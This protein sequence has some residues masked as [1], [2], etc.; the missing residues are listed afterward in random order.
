MPDAFR[1]VLAYPDVYDVGMA[2]QAI[3]ILYAALNDMEGVSCERTFVPWKDMADALRRRGAPLLA[4]E[5]LDPVAA[6]DIIG[7]TLPHELTYTNVCEL[8]D[9]AGVP[10]RACDRGPADPFV[11]AGGPCAY[12]P[13]PIAAFFDAILIGDGEEAAREI[14][15]VVREARQDGAS[16]TE[17]LERLRRIGG[18]Y[19]P[20]LDVP[21]TRTIRKR[22]VRD[23]TPFASPVCPVVPY[24]DVV[25]DRVA[26]E[27]LRGCVRGC[28]FCQAGMVY[29]PVRERG[30]DAVVRDAV[31]ALRCTGYEEVSLT[32]LSTADHS[33]FA[34]IVRRLVRRLEGTG[35]AISVPSLRLDAFTFELARLLGQ[36]KRA[37]LTFAP[38]AATQ[39]LRDVINKNITEHDVLSTVERAFAAGWRRVKLY[40]M[41]GLPTETD[42]D[43]AEIGALV[44]RVVETARGATPAGERG[45]V[46]VAVSVSTFVPKAHTPFQWEPQIPLGEVHRRHDIVRRVMPRK[47]VELSFH[48]AEASFLEAVL[49]RGGRELSDVIERAWQLGARFDAWSESFS[50]QRWMRAFEECGVDPSAIAHRAWPEDEPLPWAHVSAGLSERY[51]RIERRRALE[52]IRTPD[53]A[54]AGCTGCG[55]CGTLGGSNVIVGDRRG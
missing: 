23:L 42:E 2:N 22:L 45:S 20:L 40:F 35:I 47:G 54:V 12:N 37:S 50:L 1:V 18:V 30:A 11:I 16:R 49:A 14:A 9:L 26:I 51:L 28:R 41:I 17:V 25:H 36:G 34:D 52:G 5:S 6:F 10:L 32:S 38:E 3:Q 29:R 21:G 48:D 7:V 13:E 46:R 15:S 31:R 55:V 43:C 4:L 53:C 44:R 33:Q 8:L 19:V 27:V 39:R 24:V